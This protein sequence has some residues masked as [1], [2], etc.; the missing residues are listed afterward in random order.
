MGVDAH[1]AESAPRSA[2]SPSR[3][4]E[5]LSRAGLPGLGALGAPLPPCLDPEPPISPWLCPV[6]SGEAIR[7]GLC[8]ELLGGLREGGRSLAD[9][10]AHGF[11]LCCQIAWLHLLS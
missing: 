10:S 6:P 2:P 5:L 4:W 8:R 3:W 7:A 1:G 9:R 11:L